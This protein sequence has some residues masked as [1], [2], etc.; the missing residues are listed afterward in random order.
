[1]S[2]LRCACGHV[3]HDGMPDDLQIFCE[4]CGSPTEG[5]REG[6]TDGSFGDSAREWLI[7]FNPQCLYLW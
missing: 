2:N 3:I 5:F 4:V 1:M 7:L 6:R